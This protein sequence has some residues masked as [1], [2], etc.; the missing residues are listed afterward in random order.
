[1]GYRDR[2]IQDTENTG[3]LDVGYEEFGARGGRPRGIVH[4]AS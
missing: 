4:E 1:M 3:Q 2:G